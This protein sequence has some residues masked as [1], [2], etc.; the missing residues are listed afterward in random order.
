MYWPLILSSYVGFGFII[1]VCS[2][3]IWRRRDSRSFL[4]R[5][6]FPWTSHE[7]DVGHVPNTLCG[8]AVDGGG[9]WIICYIA[10]LSITWPVKLAWSIVTYVYV[11]FIIR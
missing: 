6:L 7:Q 11:R 10:L 2:I 1:A 8:L 5:T 3:R 9:T 4:A